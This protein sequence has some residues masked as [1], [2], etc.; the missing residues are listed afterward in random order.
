M[1]LARPRNLLT[2]SC[3]NPNLKIHVQALLDRCE[4][5]LSPSAL[6]FIMWLF[7]FP[8]F[9]V[10]IAANSSNVLQY[11]NPLIGSGNGG[12]VFAGATLP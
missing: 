11:V 10:A 6:A 4:H 2:L 12:N 1:R 8:S 7:F 5:S 3:K 9:S